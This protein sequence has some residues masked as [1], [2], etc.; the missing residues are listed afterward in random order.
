MQSRH[1]TDFGKGRAARRIG[2][3]ADLQRLRCL[4]QRQ[5]VDELVEKSGDSVRQ[6]VIGR[7]RLRSAGHQN[8]APIDQDRTVRLEKV[9]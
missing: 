3:A 2:H 9:V 8:P 1:F 4:F 6:L 7:S 5:R